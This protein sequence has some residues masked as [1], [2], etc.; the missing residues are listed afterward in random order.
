MKP[1]T[2]TRESKI[3]TM[4]W[5][6]SKSDDQNKIYSNMKIAQQITATIVTTVGMNGFASLLVIKTH[7][8]V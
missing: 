7:F 1:P 6:K 2:T 8:V 4:F 5:N 3:M